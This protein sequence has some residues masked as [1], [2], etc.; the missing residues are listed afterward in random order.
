MIPTSFE[1]AAP[2]SLS[3]ALLLLQK[4]G[5]EARILSGGHS[6]IPLMKL[7]LARP[8]MVIDLRKIKKLVGIHRKQL[9]PD[10]PM[11]LEIGAATTHAEI[12]DSDVVRKGWPLLA[13]TAAEIG[14]VQVRNAGTIGVLTP[15]THMDPPVWEKVLSVNLT[16]NWRL[17]RSMDPLLRR[18]DAGRAIF[19]T[20]G[21]ARGVF[22]FWGA[23]AVSKAALEMLVKTYAAE[24]AEFGVKAN[25]VD[26]GVVRTSMRAQAFPGE[27][28]MSLPPPEAIT[29]IFLSLAEPSCRQNG[30]IVRA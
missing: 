1:Y 8:A 15:L 21:A 12:L 19:V 10:K 26:P 29:E 3:Q 24:V 18:S 30:Q 7:R 14:D 22:P 2:A 6:L 16:A 5:E 4:H 17:L 20:S 11:G 9:E 25:L 23:Y 13:E 28:P 27:D